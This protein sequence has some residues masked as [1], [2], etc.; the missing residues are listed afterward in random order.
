MIPGWV[1]NCCIANEFDQETLEKYF[2]LKRDKSIHHIDTLYYSVFLNEPSDILELQERKRLPEGFQNML[3]TLREMKSYLKQGFDVPVEIGDDMEATLKSFSMYDFC[4]SK[5]E[6]FDIFILGHLPTA[7][8]PRCLIQLRSRFLVLEGVMDALDE[9]LRY[10]REFLAPFGLFPVKC[11]ENRIDYAFHTN[12]I[13]KP[14]KYFCDKFLRM[15]LDT[16]LRIYQKIGKIGKD[17]SVDT[18]NLGNR[19]S[20]NVYFRAYNKA[21]EVI[22]M[23]YKSFFISRWRHNELISEFDEFVYRRAYEL[24]SFRTGCLIGRLEWY[25]AHGSNEYLL[26]LCEKLIQSDYVKSDNCP[27][28]E[29]RI[30]NVIPEPTVIYN[31]EFQCKRKFF[32]SCKSWLDLN[33]VLNFKELDDWDWYDPLLSDIHCILLNSKEI[34]DYLTR[35]HGVISFVSDKNLTYKE[36][37]E[38]G[39]YMNWWKRIRSTPIKYSKDSVVELIREYDTKADIQKSKRLLMGQISRVAMLKRSD[40]TVKS[41]EDDIIDS[42]C[43]LNDNDVVPYVKSPDFADK[44]IQPLEYYNISNRK[45]RQ[46]RGIIREEDDE[47]KIIA[48]IDSGGK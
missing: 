18:F 39:S 26:E 25:L 20:N 21:R 37:L 17:I 4:I 45:A 14:G 41:F 23:N 29:R 12:L 46:L 8:T 30:H 28:I 40:T 33:H 22:E 10:L 6:C 48:A 7:E 11:C 15:H 1:L 2:G 36:F 35:Y 16:K 27:D 5:N 47:D 44:V 3:L 34:I 32:L 38:E 19:R 9:S 31:I 24:G 13:Q 43:V 42:L